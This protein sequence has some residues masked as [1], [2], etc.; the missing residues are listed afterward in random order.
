MLKRIAVGPTFIMENMTDS[1]F[2]AFFQWVSQTASSLSQ[3]FRNSAEEQPINI[4]MP[5]QAAITYIP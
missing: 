2:K 1:S 3:S 4:P 5:N